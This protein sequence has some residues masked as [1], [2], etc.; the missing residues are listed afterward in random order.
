MQ[1]SLPVSGGIHSFALSVPRSLPDP[2]PDFQ[3]SVARSEGK[4]DST[5]RYLGAFSFCKLVVLTNYQGGGNRAWMN[6]QCNSH[7]E[8]RIRIDLRYLCIQSNENVTG[9]MV[10]VKRTMN[11]KTSGLLRN[12]CHFADTLDAQFLSA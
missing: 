3:T 9:Q 12:T 8:M 2:D 11:A 5:C 1:Y 10:V 6:S 7:S 4:T